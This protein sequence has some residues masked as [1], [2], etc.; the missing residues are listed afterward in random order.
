MLNGFVVIVAIFL[1][2]LVW[3]QLF[4]RLRD[5]STLFS[6]HPKWSLAI[7]NVI[8][9]LSVWLVLTYFQH[10][11]PWL[12]DVTEAQLDWAMRA[13]QQEIPPAK[14]NDIPPFVF[15]DIDAQTHQLWEEPLFTSRQKVKEL[16]DTAVKGGARLIVVDL[17]LSQ[18]TSTQKTG[19]EGWQPF[20]WKSKKKLPS[21]PYD[22]DLYDY[23]ANYK[24]QCQATGCSPII[25]KRVFRPLSEINK[26]RNLWYETPLD[27]LRLARSEEPIRESKP[28]FLDAAV[29]KSVPYVQWAAPLWVRSEWDGAIR[30]EWLWQQIC[31]AKQPEVI[32]SISLLAATLIRQGTPQLAQQSLNNALAP[33]QQTHCG[34]SYTP[35]AVLSEPVTIA[36]GL[37]IPA[38]AH[39]RQPIKYH[40]RWQSPQNR[41]KEWLRYFLQDYDPNTRQR[42]VILTVLSAQPFLDAPKDEQNQALT[43]QVV[44]IGS[45]YIDRSEMPITPLGAM[46]SSLIN[47]NAIHSLLQYGNSPLLTLWD[48]LVW[49]VLLIIIVS[50]ILTPIESFWLIIFIGLGVVVSVP[51]GIF[52]LG[53]TIWITL[54]L[55][56]LAVHVHHIAA[57][58]RDKALKLKLREQAFAKEIKKSLA[59]DSTKLVK[60][61]AKGVEQSL[62]KQIEELVID[63]L[64][65]TMEQSEQV[66]VGLAGSEVSSSQKPPPKKSEKVRDKKPGGS[67]FDIFDN[68]RG[69]KQP[70]PE[71]N[72][73]QKQKATEEKVTP[74]SDGAG[75]VNQTDASQASQEPD[76]SSDPPKTN[77]DETTIPESD[78]S[79]EQQPSQPST[80]KTPMSVPDGL[81]DPSLKKKGGVKRVKE[82]FSRWFNRRDLVINLLVGLSVA[83]VLLYFSRNPWLME[84]EDASMDWW[85]ELNKNIIPPIQE[86]QIP[87]VVFLNV[88]DKTYYDWGEPL[89]TPR[90]QLTNLIKSAV[91]A[92]ARLVIVDLNVS[93]KTPIEGS[94]LHPEDQALKTYLTNYVDHCRSGT[95][96]AACPTIILRRSFSTQSNAIPIVRTSFLDEVITQDGPVQWASR[97]FY[98]ASDQVVRRWKLWQPACTTD[99][100]PIVVPS[101]E[102]LAMAHIKESCT[103][104][105]LQ[106]V[107]QSFQP[108]NCHD[109]TLPSLTVFKFCGLTVNLADRWGINQRIRYRLSWSDLVVDEVDTPV[110]TTLSAQ[111][112]AESLPQ[113]NTKAIASGGVVVI[114]KSYREGYDIHTAPLGELPGALI[115]VNA[116]YSLLQPEKIALSS[117][118]SVFTTVLFILI[119][120]A[121]FGRFP[122]GSGIAVSS[123][124]ILFVLLPLTM[125][126]FS[127]GMWL[128]IALPLLAVSIFQVRI[129]Q[130]V[131]NACGAV[132]GNLWLLTRRAFGFGY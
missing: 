110:L 10:T 59:K 12:T 72:G 90:E 65:K 26:D 88:D 56:L 31:M 77:V 19:F 21:T 74:D 129:F 22:Q 54:A 102:L 71:S 111:P 35:P 96:I 120:T 73:A 42:E 3:H 1:I 131:A 24:T 119:M 79:N 6:D 25:L 95:D 34:D 45:S 36:N 109:M 132:L 11:Y 18:K 29:T 108:K 68:L 103:T 81:I 39:L 97:Q 14:A 49:A 4:Y 130:T 43:D 7:A 32:P 87:P 37:V 58:Y 55:A 85:M 83:L 67:I 23:I 27:G 91:A 76:G 121:L 9:G 89:F 124:L 113:S 8:V 114:G 20:I 69:S 75:D 16:I 86:N 13:H 63:D 125:I 57:N 106:K 46:P 30:R 28:S 100:Q 118:A 104:A 5:F 128:N 78:G 99:K 66:M 2:V 116:L 41:S 62:S 48:H 47:L 64:S 115:I 33:F 51:L 126:W 98:P 93:Q 40:F 80:D 84:A 122:S 107:L 117:L 50:I 53:G 44:L 94:E 15:L 60:E 123:L 105:E 70:P 38:G 17:D 61:M 127:Y 101:L 82:L 112:Y 52:L 92:K